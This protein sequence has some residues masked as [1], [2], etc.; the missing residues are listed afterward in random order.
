MKKNED[1]KSS[2][3]LVSLGAFLW[4]TDAPLR[5]RL[6]NNFPSTFIIFLDHLLSL[7]VTIPLF[8][9]EW[10]KILKFDWKDWVS[11]LIISL[12][13]AALATIFFTQSFATTTNYTVPILIQKLQPIIAIL[14][15]SIILKESLTKR[16]WLWSIIA[17]ASAYFVSFGAT[18][19]LGALKE[20]MIVPVVYALLAAVLWGGSTVF[21]RYLL[22]KYS[23]SFVT[24]LRYIA[25]LVWL[26]I[27]VHIQNQWG[28]FGTLTWGYL[29]IFILMAFIPGFIAMF[30]YYIGL[31]ETKASIATICELTYPVS[32]VVINWIWLD[33]VL[34]IAQIIGTIVLLG[35]ITMLTYENVKK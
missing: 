11:L 14:L 6:V 28:A 3:W 1:T 20:A 9:R 19:T 21:G 24:A 18:F 29:I 27:I 15:A 34:S 17:I 2:P 10:K 5:S 30:I 25:G 23:F 32:A 13:G 33:S 12:G 31:K 35:A 16:F 22:K 7:I 26:V 4:A 8:L